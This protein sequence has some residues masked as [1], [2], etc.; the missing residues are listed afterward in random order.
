MEKL[1]HSDILSSCSGST[2]LFFTLCYSIKT[3][4]LVT[5]NDT[6]FEWSMLFTS[7]SL[8]SKQR[9]TYGHPWLM[10]FWLIACATH[11]P[12]FWTLPIESKCRTM[13]DWSQFITLA[14][15][16]VH[17]HGSLWIN[18]S[19]RSSPNPESLPERG[20]ANIKTILLKTRKPFS[21]R[22]LSD[23]FVPIHGVNV[24]GRLRCFRPSIE[25]R[26]EYRK[27]YNFSIWHSIF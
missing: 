20:V 25:L 8:T 11:T 27:F 6:D 18:M 5:S 22:A 23:D 12:D 24:S 19:K 14:S 21:C 3:Q 10:W 16:G 4:F 26:E 17:W 1:E 7:Q 13:V 9:C 15:S 2:I